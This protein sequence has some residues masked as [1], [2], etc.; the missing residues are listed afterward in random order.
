[1]EI[2]SATAVE[3]CTNDGTPLVVDPLFVR[4]TWNKMVKCVGKDI[5]YLI[6]LLHSL[7][8]PGCFLLRSTAEACLRPL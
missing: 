8:E 2:D 4:R 3:I 5:L 6:C 1:M 7:L